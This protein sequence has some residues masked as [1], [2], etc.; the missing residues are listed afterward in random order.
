MVKCHQFDLH[1]KMIIEI[2][3]RNICPLMRSPQFDYR[4]RLAET[5]S[6]RLYISLDYRE[7]YLS[8]VVDDERMR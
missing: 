2:E 5:A 7:P 6:H 4:H 1:M 8:T 3:H